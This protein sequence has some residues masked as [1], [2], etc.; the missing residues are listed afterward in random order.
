MQAVSFGADGE[1]GCWPHVSGG[2]L[3]EREFRLADE[4]VWRRRPLSTLCSVQLVSSAEGVEQLG[5]CLD[6]H[7]RPP[8]RENEGESTTDFEAGAACRL[9]P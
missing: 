2:F 7:T 4:G 1:F 3:P 6:F 9:A 5:C 8:R